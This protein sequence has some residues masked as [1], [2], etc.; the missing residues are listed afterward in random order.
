MDKEVIKC[1]T[2]VLEVR[3]QPRDQSNKE[4]GK[5][6]TICPSMHSLLFQDKQF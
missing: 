2:E 6:S 5:H 3:P 1:N 4:E